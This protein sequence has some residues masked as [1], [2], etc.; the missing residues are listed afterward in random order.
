M[1][2]WY[3]SDSP[4]N[5]LTGQGDCAIFIDGRPSLTTAGTVQGAA[6]VYK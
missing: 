5:P 2:T 4:Y 1:G 3:F 6:V